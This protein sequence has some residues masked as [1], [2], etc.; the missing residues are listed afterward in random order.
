MDLRH[1]HP[2]TCRSV[3]FGDGGHA[4]SEPHPRWQGPE[5]YFGA[6]RTN[7]ADIS[8]LFWRPRLAAEGEKGSVKHIRD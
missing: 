7:Q 6:E 4:R 5:A 8:P 3:G 1:C 2:G